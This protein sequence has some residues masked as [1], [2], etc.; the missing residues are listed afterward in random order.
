MNKS[1]VIDMQTAIGKIPSGSTVMIGGFTN[2]GG[3]NNLINAIAESDIENLTTISE[4]LGWSGP[5]FNQGISF[6][7]EKGKVSGVITSFIGR[8]KI[9]NELIAA[10]KVQLTLVPQGTLIERIRSA[11]AGIGGFYTPTGVGTVV[12]EGKEIKEIDGKTYLLELPLRA[13]VALI[14]A[15]TADTMGNAIF[16]YTGAN[17]NPA[18]ATAA[19][20]VILETENLVEPGVIEPDRFHL[21]GVFVDYIVHAEEV[22]F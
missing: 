17:Y 4:D 6:L 12:Q 1:K 10:G 2:F 14:K 13:D 18:M 20:L 8:N 11:G 15:H 5:A 7:M 21:P 9:A 22:A 3:P 16:R 19:D